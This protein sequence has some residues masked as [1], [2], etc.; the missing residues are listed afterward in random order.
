M[1]NNEEK[2]VEIK[3]EQK[4]KKKG[5]FIA[6]ILIVLALICFGCY[7][8]ISKGIFNQKE[9]SET[10]ESE[11][12]E[13]EE[14][15]SEKIYGSGII[16]D[17]IDASYQLGD[18]TVNI[19]IERI[20]ESPN[21]FVKLDDNDIF[22][23][24]FGNVDKHS[25][26]DVYIM[27]DIIIVTTMGTDIRTYNIYFFDSNGKQIKVIKNAAEDDSRMKMADYE[28]TD[29]RIIFTRSM[30]SHGPSIDNTIQIF[31]FSACK[32]LIKENNI[33]EGLV[34]KSEYEI[35]YLGNNKFSEETNTKNVT[36]E[37]YVESAEV[38]QL[39]N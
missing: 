24:D 8:A 10:N 36:I 21:Y 11:K 33:P 31:D 18:K 29:N 4:S 15:K 7:F 25:L 13:I 12:S 28:V 32:S 37:E 23:S 2:K 1:E 14:I 34:V 19:K 3:E 38:Q 16:A 22:A 30:I 6:I 20:D 5:N 17:T 9:K 27:G 26:K 39:C 35:K